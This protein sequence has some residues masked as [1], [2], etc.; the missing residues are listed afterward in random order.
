MAGP[1]ETSSALPRPPPGAPLLA[2][3][4]W[5]LA[6]LED[7]L[8]LIA[9]FAIFGVMA[10]GIVQILG[11]SVFSGLNALLP[12]I[13]R[14]AIHGYIDYIQFIAILLLA[15]VLTCCCVIFKAGEMFDSVFPSCA[16]T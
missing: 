11:R 6:R 4:H 14:F 9:A 2:R 5:R 3:A 16:C 12:S 10:F 13:P 8:N 15:S 1:S 7:V